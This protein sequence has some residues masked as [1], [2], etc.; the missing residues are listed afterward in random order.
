MH[1]NIYCPDLI[2]HMQ[3]E[4]MWHMCLVFYIAGY[5]GCYAGSLSELCHRCV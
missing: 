4:A 5:V 1:F 2:L 3:E